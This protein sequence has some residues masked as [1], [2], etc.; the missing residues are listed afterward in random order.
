MDRGTN[1]SNDEED[2]DH[3]IEAMTKPE[4]SETKAPEESETKKER[5]PFG[6]SDRVLAEHSPDANLKQASINASK[7]PRPQY[8]R[9]T[10]PEKTTAEWKSANDTES[11]QKRAP[12]IKFSPSTKPHDGPDKEMQIKCKV[13]G[14]D[15]FINHAR[16]GWS[17]TRLQKTTVRKRHG[18]AQ[19]GGR[20]LCFVPTR[21]LLQEITAA[22]SSSTE[23]DKKS[24]LQESAAAV[25]SSTD[26]DEEDAVI[27]TTP[28]QIVQ[29]KD[30]CYMVDSCD[31][32]RG[33]VSVDS[34][35]DIFIK[36]SVFDIDGT[37]PNNPDRGLLCI[38]VENIDDVMK[39]V[40]E[41][42]QFEYA[43]DEELVPKTASLQEKVRVY[44]TCYTSI[45]WGCFGVQSFD[46]AIYRII[47]AVITK[48]KYK[49][50]AVSEDAS[51]EEKVAMYF[52]HSIGKSTL[53]DWQ[54]FGAPQFV[55]ALVDL[56]RSI[57]DNKSYKKVECREGLSLEQKVGV[58][59]QSHHGIALID[60]IV[61]K[62]FRQ[63]TVGIP[64]F[65]KSINRKKV[66]S[67]ML[68]KKA[69]SPLTQN[70]GGAVAPQSGR[71]PSARP[72]KKQ[73]GQ[74]HRTPLR[75]GA[76][77]PKSALK[78]SAPSTNETP[79]PLEPSHS[80]KALL[81]FEKS[82]AKEREK[83]HRSTVKAHKSAVKQRERTQRAERQALRDE[84]L[85]RELTAL[86]REKTDLA[87]EQTA[88]EREKTAQAHA[89]MATK[90]LELMQSAYQQERFPQAPTPAAA[91]EPPVTGQLPSQGQNP[92]GSG[93]QLSGTA[94][95]QSAARSNQPA[96]P[97]AASPSSAGPDQLDTTA[98]TATVSVQSGPPAPAAAVNPE[99]Q[100]EAPSQPDPPV[101][102]DKGALVLFTGGLLKNQGKTGTIVDFNIWMDK[103]SVKL[104][105]SAS[106][107]G[108][109]DKKNLRPL[110]RRQY[111]LLLQPSVDTV[112]VDKRV[113]GI[114]GHYIR[115]KG[116]VAYVDR[117]KKNVKVQFD[118]GNKPSGMIDI[119]KIK[120]EIDDL[121]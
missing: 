98:T 55:K 113:F 12:V 8:N 92:Q 19:S 39:D 22:V 117:E 21:S 37:D 9:E 57:V 66:P 87:R 14:T 116:T 20:K 45:D 103:A 31:I 84:N 104:D 26:E 33:N 94:A 70:R 99:Q 41:S 32:T 93:E 64:E 60:P 105:D 51:L 48:Q 43:V 23:E 44:V 78:Q 53:D 40:I 119:N 2:E 25:P 108:M 81:S 110:N 46:H 1:I 120:P 102:F 107:T 7:N 61:F 18:K 54:S 73:D 3:F 118:G 30:E 4:E 24:L 69:P 34:D 5:G 83:T 121:L 27:Y 115:Q 111:E 88:L 68:Y 52:M 17:R 89:E 47:R 77:P 112:T 96:P 63:A 29:V 16:D 95:S 65:A 85:A 42:G 74:R 59:L 67:S 90:A 106:T 79:R 86:E 13:G 62:C 11:T 97:V 38:P 100:F 75:D 6:R 58:Y 109:V 76:V 50:L 35:I 114:A 15:A 28:D 49:N 56:L 10:P 101:G 80:N 71:K 91:A 82:A 36:A 72:T